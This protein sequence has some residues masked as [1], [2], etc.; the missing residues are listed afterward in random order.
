[1]NADIAAATTVFLAVACA[2]AIG[3][4]IS[5]APRLVYIHQQKRLV[6]AVARWPCPLCFEL[7]GPQAASGL[8]S[9]KL[10]RGDKEWFYAD[11]SR[12]TEHQRRSARPTWVRVECRNCA[13]RVI[14]DE[15]GTVAEVVGSADLESGHAN[16]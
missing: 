12:W 13:A 5:F 7:L 1:M 8:A 4:A 9:W 6:E 10:C 11:K 16:Q 15:Q 3:V 2:V 14:Y